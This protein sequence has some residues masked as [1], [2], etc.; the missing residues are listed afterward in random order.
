MDI[1]TSSVLVKSRSAEVRDAGVLTGKKAGNK[2]WEKSVEQRVICGR[3]KC[4][5]VAMTVDMHRI[6]VD[7]V[8]LGHHV[9]LSVRDN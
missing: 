9:S 3:I 2:L 1:K 5:T 4:G 8:F 6:T 7:L